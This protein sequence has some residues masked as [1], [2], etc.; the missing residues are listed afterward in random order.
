MTSYGADIWLSFKLFERVDLEY[1]LS[2]IIN[3]DKKTQGLFSSSRFQ[4][5]PRCRP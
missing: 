5:P 4:V 2:L 3:K 1:R